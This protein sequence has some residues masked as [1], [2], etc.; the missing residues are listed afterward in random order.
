MSE[1]N[2]TTDVTGSIQANMT[3][4]QVIRHALPPETVWFNI[5]QIFAQNGLSMENC[6][7]QADTAL[8]LYNKRFE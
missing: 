5:F 4:N 8:R 1:E 2:K 3:A 7:A 6:A